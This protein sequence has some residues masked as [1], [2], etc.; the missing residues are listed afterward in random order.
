MKKI[1]FL[2]FLLNTVAFAFEN[3]YDFGRGFNINNNIWIGGYLTFSYKN[4]DDKGSLKFEDIALLSRISFGNISLFSEIEAKNIY[5]SS[6]N[7]HKR[8]G[9]NKYIPKIEKSR[10]WHFDFEIE[11]LFIEYNYNKYLNFKVGRFLTPLGIWNKIHIDA[12]KWTV[13]DPLVSTNFFP[14]FTTGIDLYG[15]IPLGR[16]IKYNIFVQ[17]NENINPSYNNLK[18]DKLTG[19]QIEKIVNINQRYGFN[20]G[21]FDEDISYER[22]TFLGIFGKTKIKKLY[23]SSEIFYAFEKNKGNVKHKE[24]GKITYYIQSAYRVFPSHYVVFRKDGLYDSS[25]DKTI[26]IWTVCWNY[27]PRFNVS[28]KV[29]YQIF[30]KYPDCFRLSFALLF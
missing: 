13:S 12:L 19:F 5:I 17:R 3:K 26:D 8:T 30:E 18:V 10:N 15:F 25:D 23:F 29:E 2:F 22:Y 20:G 27:R 14:M 11:R 4:R 6:F 24:H 1:L 21:I 9:N 28:F 7:S 16:N